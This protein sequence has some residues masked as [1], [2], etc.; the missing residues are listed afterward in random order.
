MTE[1]EI[2][3]LRAEDADGKASDDARGTGGGKEK[4][5]VL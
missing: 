5:R 1:A 4:R 2:R 3:P